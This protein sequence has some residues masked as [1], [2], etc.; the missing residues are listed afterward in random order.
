MK[1]LASLTLTLSLAFG[2]LAACIDMDDNVVGTTSSELGLQPGG[3]NGNHFYW[4]AY[5]KAPYIY[6]GCP[7]PG[8]EPWAEAATLF[9]RRGTRVV[10]LEL[11]TAVPLNIRALEVP[12][13]PYFS[14]R[15]TST[16][17]NIA[18]PEGPQHLRFSFLVNSGRCNY[19]L[20]AEIVVE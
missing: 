10:E 2:G 5:S 11:G 3:P 12:P 16:G 6:K 9:A 14:F 19:T 18:I 15:P 1:T 17:A 8:P 4:A 20:D 7:D 13:D